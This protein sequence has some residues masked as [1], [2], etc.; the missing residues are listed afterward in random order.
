MPILSFKYIF[1]FLFVPIGALTAQSIQFTEIHYDPSTSQGSD[2]DYEFI[3]IFNSGGSSVDLSNYYFSGI[4]YTFSSGASLAAGAYIVLAR[5][6]DNY[7]GSLEWSSGV[8]TNGGETLTLYDGSENVIDQVT[9]DNAS[10][11]PTPPNGDGPSL[12]LK[13]PSSDNSVGSNWTYSYHSGGTP[14]YANQSIQLTGS[15]GWRI[16][17]LPLQS[18]THDDLLSGIWTQGFTGADATTGTANVYTYSGSAWASIS[19]QTDTPTAGTGFLVYVYSDDNND[20]SAEGFPKTITLSGSEYAATVSVTTAAS[21]WNLLGNPFTHTID[22]DKLSLGGSGSGTNDNYETAVYVWDNSSGTFKSY[23]ASTSSGTLTG[24]LIEPFQ[25]FL[26]QSKTSGT[27]FDFKSS[28]KAISSGAFYKTS[29][30]PQIIIQASTGSFQDV[31]ILNVIPSSSLGA[32]GAYKLKPVDSRERM[33]MAFFNDLTPMEIMNISLADTITSISFDAFRI[34]R[35]WALKPSLIDLDWQLINIPENIIVQ[36][37]DHGTGSLINLSD[38]NT[39]SF[40]NREVRQ[41][42]FDGDNIGN[43]P[44]Y[45]SPRFELIIRAKML[46]DAKTTPTRFRLYPA[47]PNPFNASTTIEFEL[48]EKSHVE[49]TV[50]NI[51]GK[52][53]AT[54]TNEMMTA[55][56]QTIRW[57]PNHLSSGIYFCRLRSGTTVRTIKLVLMK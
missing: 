41:P 10:T 40:Y 29:S 30:A 20:G 56:N 11:W 44:S 8:L 18:K 26:I 3:E 34:D 55:G 39:I 27:Q 1:F 9:F 12:E 53:V 51:R 52:K 6:S 47:F 23:D 31:A 17:S 16:M 48:L 37:I 2:S 28:S 45:R 32:G 4:S 24:G 54:I 21:T 14:G 42:E 46:L 49:I 57:R 33:L 43:I 5:Q 22:A 36:L 50:Y 7:S 25:G 35:D 13:D 38:K 19:N 15:A